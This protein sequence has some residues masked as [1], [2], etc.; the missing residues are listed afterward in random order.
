M[1]ND[2]GVSSRYNDGAKFG[3]VHTA[4][5]GTFRLKMC[6]QCRF[7]STRWRVCAAVV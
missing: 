3:K 5:A 4:L 7:E 1:G 6:V 2:G